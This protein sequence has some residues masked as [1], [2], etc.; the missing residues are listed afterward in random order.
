MLK[1]AERLLG[2]GGALAALATPADAQNGA[3][4]DITGLWGAVISAKDNSFPAFP[5]FEL[6]GDGT[7]IG[8]GQ[9][10]LTP[11]AL[12][13]SAW[14]RWTKV[15]DRKFHLIARFW[16]Y[17]PT[18]N[19]PGFAT[20]DFTVT[21]SPAGKRNHGVGPIQFFAITGTPLCPPPPPSPPTPPMS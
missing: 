14:G 12:G 9:P 4:D 17:D 18:A 16:T 10:D 2:G 13:S 7:F 11:A 8:S 6:W 3:P 19:P 15:A 21:L 5:A 20:V 1:G